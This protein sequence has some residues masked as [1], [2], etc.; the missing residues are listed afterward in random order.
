MVPFLDRSS[1]A[2]RFLRV[3]QCSFCNLVAA[4]LLTTNLIAQKTIRVPADVPTIQGAI[5]MAVNG[6]VVIVSSGTYPENID[7]TGKAITVKG[8]GAAGA[9]IIDGGAQASVVTFD[10]GET[11]NSV[12]SNLTLQNGAPTTLPEAGGVYINGSSPT[13]QN[14]IIQNNLECGIGIYSGAP[15]VQGNLIQNTTHG[16]LEGCVAKTGSALGYPGQGAGIFM[17]GYSHDGQQAQFIGNVI[18]GNKSTNVSPAGMYLADA[19][20]PLVKNNIITKNYSEQTSALDIRGD[21][22][23][24]IIQNLIYQNAVDQSQVEFPA[25]FETSAVSVV[26]SGG[27]FRDYAP[28]IAN[29]TIAN[30][31]YVAIPGINQQGSQLYVGEDYNLTQITNN[32]I[33]GTGMSSLVNCQPSVPPVSPPKFD[34]NDVFPLGGGTTYYGTC[35]DPTGSN[36]NISVDPQFA[37]TDSA[38]QYPYQLQL[39]SPVV[40][41]GDNSVPDLPAE[42]LLGKPRIQ[43]AKGLPTSVIDMGVYEYPG[44]PAPPPPADFTLSLNPQ[45]LKLETGQEGAVIVTLTPTSSFQGNVALTCGT[46]PAA[47]SCSFQ[48]QQVN[49]NNGVAQ[50]ARLIVGTQKV[51]PS[52]VIAGRFGSSR[53]STPTALSVLVGYLASILLFLQRRKAGR[54]LYLLLGIFTMTGILGSLS[55]CGVT[56]NGIS[57][58]YSI[59]VYGTGTSGQTTHQANIGL[60]VLP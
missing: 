24:L 27:V 31:T 39:Q 3:A 30:N 56:F 9:T 19:G 22:A 43:N 44:L 23:P 1:L 57:E 4:V 13:I 21:V 6:D 10:S 20:A 16:I 36:G 28:V 29:N 48:P 33:T 15:L 26:P 14:N 7:F 47:V 35:S 52:S 11:R 25:A 58:A 59:A 60:N 50:T 53:I 42:D 37:S 49:L 18:Q 34:H 41:A 5:N 32:I 40:D 51:V 38:A 55:A 2:A 17:T 46:L 45:S 12:L 54:R 8:A